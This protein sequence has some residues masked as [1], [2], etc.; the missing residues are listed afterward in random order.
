MAA[1]E[2]LSKHWGD[3]GYDPGQEQ[4]VTV[5]FKKR[6]GK[7]VTV[8]VYFHAKSNGQDSYY[9]SQRHNTVYIRI[10][11]IK[12]NGEREKNALKTHSF[13]YQ[14]HGYKSSYTLP[15]SKRDF[16]FTA[17]YGETKFVVTYE[18]WRHGTNTPWYG[19]KSTGQVDETKLGTLKVNDADKFDIKYHP[20]G[21]GASNAEN[22]PDDTKIYEMKDYTVSS[23]IPVDKINRYV[24]TGWTTKKPG[25]GVNLGKS[26]TKG[27]D[28]I[29]D[30]QKN[31][32]LYACWKKQTYTYH[33]Y[34]T[35]EDALAQ[36]NE[37][38]D[39][40][41]TRVYGT[42][43][44]CLVPDLNGTDKCNVGY[45]HLGWMHVMPDEKDDAFHRLDVTDPEATG[46]RDCRRNADTY[47]WPVYEAEIINLIF[48]YGF[49]N[50]TNTRQYQIG[51]TFNF[52]YVCVEPI[53]GKVVSNVL[54]RPGFRLV[55]WSYKQPTKILSPFSSV[56]SDYTYAYNYNGVITGWPES[57]DLSV[58]VTLY[59][60]YEYHSRIFVYTRNKWRLA[61]PF[62]A[63]KD[64]SRTTY[65]YEASTGA[66]TDMKEFTNWIPA[67]PFV[68]SKDDWR[69]S[70]D[71]KTKEPEPEPS[72]PE[73][74]EAYASFNSDTNVLTFFVD[75][76][77]K[78]ENG[79]VED[80]ITYYTGIEDTSESIPWED[81]K[82]NIKKVV[83]NDVIYS[84]TVANWF[85]GCENLE[86]IVEFE[87][88]DLS[89]CY[90]MRELCRGCTSLK[91]IDLS[92]VDATRV[93]FMDYAF[94]EC[95]ELEK[96]YF[97]STKTT[98][99]IS[100]TGLFKGCTK[101][102]NVSIRCT[103][104][105]L[106]DI[107]FLFEGCES[108]TGANLSALDTSK[109]TTMESVFDGCKSLKNPRV[110]GFHTNEVIT[111]K[112]MFRNC[113]AAEFI[114]LTSFNTSKVTD[115]T[116]MFEGCSSLLEIYATRNNKNTAKNYSGQFNRNSLPQTKDET[117]GVITYQNSDNM[118]LGCAS[119]CGKGVG[120]KKTKKENNKKN[121]KSNY[122]EE[123]EVA[124]TFRYDPEKINATYAQ[125]AWVF[126]D[127]SKINKLNK[128][129]EKIVDHYKVTVYKEVSKKVTKTTT[130][131][132][133]VETTSTT[134]EK[135]KEV[136]AT[137]EF[138]KDKKE[139]AEKYAKEWNGKKGYS[140]KMST[141]YKKLVVNTITGNEG[142]F[143]TK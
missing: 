49:D 91:T 54:V 100:M 124:V 30:V 70:G 5:S 44:G 71:S 11:R 120:T 143:R 137:K 27:G 3:A 122:V 83:F 117:T 110:E 80:N 43:P 131:D 58:G 22:M 82:P 52:K 132:K 81:N 63:V 17:D 42:K 114:D 129:G 8:H 47:C 111:M 127:E 130:D 73:D 55:G 99:I 16:T 50:Y 95:T 39:L 92:N 23:K 46:H 94:A 53:D 32:N 108:L 9:Y 64:P 34:P 88:M 142:Y 37:Y 128:K 134:T 135:V 90:D 72:L 15:D 18:N 1:K 24:F 12:N 103:S 86:E 51:T 116:S 118:F 2:K 101:L 96:A 93:E 19:P 77:G 31:I 4:D 35:Q 33:Y 125:C 136:Y 20:G 112:A 29:K 65:N 121:D 60:V 106:R 62:V 87:L 78:Y 126:E 40:K 97:T 48:D 57:T 26:D 10:Y 7:K 85:S 59:A 113:A 25:D 119:L 105:N 74:K 140:A 109:V 104:N 75:T 13:S 141:I 102:K 79:Q 68:Y 41:Q 76:K 36:T 67:Y 107:S 66:R 115:M 21:I 133:G 56:A 123:S 6:K 45:E 61:L 89:G 69:W 14:C 138:D 98:V 28:K 38:T 84:W 139:K